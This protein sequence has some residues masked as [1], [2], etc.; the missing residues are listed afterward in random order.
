[1]EKTSHFLPGFLVGGLF[2]GLLTFVAAMFG[3]IQA[4]DDAINSISQTI[5]NQLQRSV[6]DANMP[7]CKITNHDGRPI[8][9]N[10]ER[11]GEFSLSVGSIVSIECFKP[12]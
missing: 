6:F 2:F 7:G 3:P 4:R 10:N 12:N 9:E 11:P 1:M 8:T 5:N